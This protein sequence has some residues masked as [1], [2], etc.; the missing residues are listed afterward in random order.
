MVE[1]QIDIPFA[2]LMVSRFAKNPGLDHFSAVDQ[3]LRYLASSQDR[4]ITFGGEPILHLVGYSDSDWA[5]D[6]ADRKST[7]RFVFTLNGGP[8]SYG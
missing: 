6:H 3:I 8:I 5:G 1:T 7:S 2:I 4:G